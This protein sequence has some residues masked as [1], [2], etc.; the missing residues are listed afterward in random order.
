VDHRLLTELSGAAV[1]VELEAVL[2]SCTGAPP[3]II[4]DHGSE[5]CNVELRAVIKAHDLIDLRPRPPEFNGIVERETA[6]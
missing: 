2:A 1:S 6:L 4:H 3:R 5:F